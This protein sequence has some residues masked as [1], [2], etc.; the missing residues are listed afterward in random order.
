MPVFTSAKEQRLWT[1][2]LLVLLA[3]FAT[4]F[5]GQPLEQLFR[6]QDVRAAVFLLVMLLV[7]AAILV[8]SLKTKPGKTEIV[9][10][11]G[12]TAVYIMFFL[13]LGMP[14]RS[15][16]MEYSILAIFIHKALIERKSQGRRIPLPALLALLASFMIGVL[17]ECIQLFLPYRVFDPED[18]LFNGLA[19]T[20]AIGSYLI[21]AWVR[22]KRSKSKT[23][24]HE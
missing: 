7:G 21:L 23:E 6:S 14:E 20:M 9:V 10:L 4:L 5:L 12:I 8:H 24:K 3:I 16:L 13:R 2:A 17:D 15:H 18:I 1:W 11:L 22:K 19:I